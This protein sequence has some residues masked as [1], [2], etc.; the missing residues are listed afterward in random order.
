MANNTI[1]TK[2]LCELS[3]LGTDRLKQLQEAGIIAKS[4]RATWPAL[5]TLSK[6]IL[7]Y[8]S[9]ARRGHRSAADSEWRRI[10]AVELEMRVAERAH[11]LIE[12]DES[13]AVVQDIVGTIL[14]G[15]GSLPARVAGKDLALRRKIEAEVNTIR[16]TAAKRLQEQATALRTTGEV[17][18]APP[19]FGP[20]NGTPAAN[21]GATA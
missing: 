14:T 4:A 1:S 15:L 20:M 17:S 6:L 12:T 7:Y 19:T 11:K 5:E 10:K 8:R 9:E 2:R 13:I 21:D 3:G 18:T 16:A